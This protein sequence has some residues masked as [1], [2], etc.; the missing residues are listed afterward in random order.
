VVK[1]WYTPY[2]HKHIYPA[3]GRKSIPSSKRAPTNA[4]I[5]LWN[6]PLGIPPLTVWASSVPARLVTS[7]DFKD[8]LAASIGPLAYLTILAPQ[9]RGPFVAATF[10]GLSMDWRYADQVS[11]VTGTP[12]THYIWR[13][14]TFGSAYVSVYYRAWIRPLPI[15]PP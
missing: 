10:T 12:A 3:E 7:N 13:T 6:G 8:D 2:R 1:T 9:P 5:D 11:L 4:L 14:E 15:P